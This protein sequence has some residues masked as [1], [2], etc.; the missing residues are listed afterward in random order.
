MDE[1]QRELAAL[2]GKA[3][4]S[5][6]PWPPHP[7]QIDL[8]DGS[9]LRI[10]EAADETGMSESTIRRLRYAK[11]VRVGSTWFINRDRLLAS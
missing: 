9:W 3:E 7:S 2:L 8:K 1:L 6:E 11:G 4:A 10:K 5:A